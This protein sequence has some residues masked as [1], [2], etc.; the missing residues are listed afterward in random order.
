MHQIS[1][2]RE[3]PHLKRPHCEYI[4]PLKGS[5][6]DDAYLINVASEDVVDQSTLV[7]AL[8]SKTL[9]GDYLNEYKTIHMSIDHT[10]DEH[11]TYDEEYQMTQL[12]PETA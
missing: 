11:E 9:A 2:D 12:N 5:L 1:P 4:N 7:A 6:R 3:I 8:E 10:A